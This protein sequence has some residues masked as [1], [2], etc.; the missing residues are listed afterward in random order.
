MTWT[1]DL[2]HS[3]VGFTVRHLMI[4]KVRGQFNSFSAEV[5]V[6]PDNVANTKV[7][8]SI[9]ANSID[10]NNTDRD[11][12]LRSP[13]FFNIEEYP[14]LEFESSAFRSKGDGKIEVD[15]QL[16]IRGE[17]HPITLTGEQQ[18]PAANP[19]SGQRTVGF[20]LHGEI[21]RELYG[22]TWNQGLE[23]GGVMVGKKVTIEIDAEAVEG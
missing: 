18:G 14:T 16:T 13:D 15:G 21:D 22:L 17:T 9:D 10:T 6:D 19:F 12:H 4:S 23:T 8:A 3:K 11:N 20:S 2:A 5:E 7:R 1:L